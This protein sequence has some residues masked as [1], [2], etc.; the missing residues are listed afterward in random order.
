MSDI[1]YPA[2][3]GKNKD[4][5]RGTSPPNRDLNAAQRAS[6][7]IRLRSEM[8]TY[9]EIAKQIGVSQPSSARKIVKR[10]LDRVI[11]KDVEELRTAELHMLN[12]MHKECWELFMDRKNK[13]R[14]FAADR[15]LAIA[16][17]RA[18]LMGLD[19]PVDSAVAANMVVIREVPQ[20]YLSV[21]V[22]KP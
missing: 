21:E 18:K 6:L 10:E 4:N 22:P 13:G 19:T 5:Q 1:N 17:R 11:V 7:A 9:D 20:G 15:I 12:T 3:T 8:L 16:E 2:R 14:L